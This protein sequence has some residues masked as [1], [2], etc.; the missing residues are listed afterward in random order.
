M[1]YRGLSPAAAD[2]FVRARRP[3]I[4]KKWDSVTVRAVAAL[5]RHALSRLAGEG[6]GGGG[7][8]G[9]SGSSASAS[10]SGAPHPAGKVDSWPEGSGSAGSAALREALARVVA[11]VL[12]EPLG[13]PDGAPSAAARHA[14]LGAAL[15]RDRELAEILRARGLLASP[16]AGE[17]AYLVLDGEALLDAAQSDLVSVLSGGALG[18]GAGAISSGSAG[19]AASGSLDEAETSALQGHRSVPNG[20]GRR[21]GARTPRTEPTS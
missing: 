13:A 2:A 9:A 19:E 14:L 11:E 20:P 21:G 7:G 4:S 6:A 8:G 5:R 17:G 1:L 3:H 15:A 16:P 10:A 12:G 18:G